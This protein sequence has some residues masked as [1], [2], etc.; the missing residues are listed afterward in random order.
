M[1]QATSSANRRNLRW[2]VILG[3]SMSKISAESGRT[4]R[5]YTYHNRT[6]SLAFENQMTNKKCRRNEER[7]TS[8]K[9]HSTMRHIST[10]LRHLANMPL[11]LSGPVFCYF[12]T[13]KSTR[14]LVRLSYLSFFAMST[15]STRSRP[16]RNRRKTKQRK[17]AKHKA[18]STILLQYQ[19]NITY[20][21][22]AKH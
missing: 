10:Y 14:A 12:R 19:N 22:H 5:C 7:D 3:I 2:I 17:N 21:Y 8:R 9:H 11:T 4:H 13:R 20:I 15:R 16:P 6:L 1:T 18:H